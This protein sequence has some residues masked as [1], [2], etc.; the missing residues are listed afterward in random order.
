MATVLSRKR[1]SPF[2]SSDDGN[3]KSLKHDFD[4]IYRM[5]KYFFVMIV[6]ILLIDYKEKTLAILLNNKNRGSNEQKNTKN[7]SKNSKYESQESFDSYSFFENPCFVCQNDVEDNSLK[8]TF[9]TGIC[10]EGCLVQCEKCLDIY[11]TLC[12]TVK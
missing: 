5:F 6:P 1:R 11:C 12:S 9:C 10:C 4:A 3:T 8:C 2:T 7:D